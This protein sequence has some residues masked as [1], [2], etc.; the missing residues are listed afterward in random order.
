MILRTVSH[1]SAL[2]IASCLCVEMRC[3]QTP[4]RNLSLTGIFS[5]ELPPGWRQLTPD[6]ARRLKKDPGKEFPAALIHPG[7]RTNMYPYGHVDRWLAGGFDG[8]CLCV[9]LSE[10]EPGMDQESIDKILSFAKESSAAGHRFDIR[11]SRFSKLGE[12][13][14]SVIETRAVR[15][16]EDGARPMQELGFYVP[17]GGQTLILAFR[18]FEEDFEQVLPT[19]ERAAATLRFSRPPRGPKRQTNDIV[20]AAIVGAFVGV[21]L[22]LLRRKS[23]AG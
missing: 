18:S 16:F 15:V 23:R 19:F 13:G 17:T 7:L 2:L 20:W 5:L 12:Q 11:S 10:G 6:E 21:L 14:Q 22:L 1:M 8:R 3:Q 9:Q 4:T